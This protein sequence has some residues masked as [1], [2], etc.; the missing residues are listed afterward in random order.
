MDSGDT[1][2]PRRSPGSA[3]GPA[4]E[5]RTAPP[6]FGLES[7][8]LSE[9]AADGSA[10]VRTPRTDAFA[11][12]LGALRD[13][14]F[15]EAVAHVADEAAAVAEEPFY[16]GEE[17]AQQRWRQ[18]QAAATYLDGVASR[19]EAAI[20][21]LLTETEGRDLTPMSPE[22]LE[23]YLEG[24]APDSAGGSPAT[25]EF[26]GKLLKKAKKAVG[27]AVAL[28][29]KGLKAVSNVLPHTWILKKLLGLVRPLL[30]RVLRFAVDKLP[31]AL[32]PMAR[33]LAAKVLGT[34]VPASED[35]GGARD[36][37]ASA[38]PRMLAAETD[39]LLAGYLVE[40][41]SFER[42][43]GVETLVEDRRTAPARDALRD[44]DR[45][46]AT[47][48]GQLERLRDGE[49]PT[50]AVEQFVPAILAALRL[51]VRM[52]GR[53]KIVRFLSGHLGR[54]IQPHVGDG[55]AAALSTALVDAGLKL[56][57]L[58]AESETQAGQRA[59]A[60]TLATTVED[61][62]AR[63]VQTLPSEEWES[64][65]LLEAYARE[66]FEQAVAGNFPDDTVRSE[67]HEAN[68]VKGVWS[69][70][71]G[72][73]YKKYSRVPSVVLTPQIA[74]AIPSFRGVPL[75]ALL[76]DRFGIV[77]P[78]RV[79]VHLYEAVA[80][81]TPGAITRG[82]QAPGAPA[83]AGVAG[84]RDAAQ[85]AP[86]V[87]AARDAASAGGLGNA[88]NGTP[89]SEADLHPLT[90][91]TAGLLLREPGLGRSVDDRFLETPDVLA[92]GQR[93][94]SL[95]VA[96]AVK[97]APQG[98]PRT[99]RF[100][101]R[102]DLARGI[103]RVLIYL[104]EASAQQAAQALRRKAPAGVVLNLLR[105][106][107]ESPARPAAESAPDVRVSSASLAEEPE[108]LARRVRRGMTPALRRALVG[109]VVRALGT[110]LDRRYA[111][112]AG[113]LDRAANADADGI[114]IRVEL[115]GLS[116][117]GAVRRLAAGVGAAREDE[118]A[119]RSTAA[120]THT[121]QIVPG[122]AS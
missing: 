81:T 26:I 67:L 9:Y 20:E 79:N 122:Y 103:V 21:R 91:A 120:A 73:R 15:D 82:E 88:A 2:S 95:E 61:T 100:R 43:A 4:A 74:R 121:V 13:E 86:A 104:S 18:Q 11:E 57:Q 25:E 83:L 77:G 56:V 78:I 76:R 34:A 90:E 30:Q 60:D 63:L 66:A 48:A 64:E 41:E 110:E 59:A 50:P 85:A 5:T 38:D 92:I 96:N 117:M 16:E 52:I 114:T 28:A 14:E 39:T 6:S 8:F 69:R 65:T 7:P 44:L 24:L 68:E 101:V 71:R 111:Q 22:A 119:P 33:Q 47:F 116:W 109:S 98:R 3:G 12:L 106:T 84:A 107:F 87:G 40:G 29:K 118:G 105:R 93:L 45:A 10:G 94:Y 23:A 42:G 53:P 80:G 75:Q 27:G 35:E 36:E 97:R 17:P 62:V 115:S 99:R 102:F 55:N 89:K 31:V 51:G 112:F 37:A 46:R 54:L 108:E 32:Q 1:V 113:E 72:R 70:R 58:E 49:D 19:A